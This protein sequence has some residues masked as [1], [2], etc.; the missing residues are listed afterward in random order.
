MT[1]D[2]PVLVVD[3]EPH[4]GRIIKTRLEQGPFRVTL[5]E[6]GPL[7]LQALAE[8]PDTQ[9]LILDLMLPGMSGLDVLRTV[10]ADPRW[11]A[12][13]CI[14]LTAAGRDDQYQEAGA[15]GVADFMT[16]P[17]SPR[18]LF[19]RALAITGAAASLPGGRFAMSRWC[20][21]LAGGVGSRFWPVSTPERPKQLLPL[22]SGTPML[23]D[24]LARVA[25]V[26]APAQTLI[27]TNASLAP[28]VRALASD[29]P[30]DHVVAEPRPAG[31]CAALAWAAQLIE[32]ADGPEAVMVCVHADWSIG[33]VPTF[34]DTLKLAADVAAE[35]HA[36]VT[37]GIVPSR[38][39]PGFGYIQPGDAIAEGGHPR[40]AVCGETRPHARGGDG[41]GRLSVE[42]RHL[43]VARGGS[44][45]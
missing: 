16:K 25:P 12:L 20:V 43:R 5:A 13:P 30:A 32:R 4:I 6:A 3:D 29:V 35:R 19:S 41:G 26:A 21:V 33:D 23:A 34:Q 36:L 28:A 15:L 39:D 37:V 42:L 2:I 9:L 7:A 1:P 14:I 24:T 17:F 18:R 11:H 27:L 10:R 31:T 44:A 38:P 40:R 8:Q 45:R 22:V